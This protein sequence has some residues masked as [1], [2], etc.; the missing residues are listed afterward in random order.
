[1]FLFTLF[2]F[3]FFFLGKDGTSI[4]IESIVMHTVCYWCPAPQEVVTQTPFRPSSVNMPSLLPLSSFGMWLF[5]FATQALIC[6]TVSERE[7][8]SSVSE[9]ENWQ[10]TS[11]LPVCLPV[12]Y[13]LLPPP[14]SVITSSTAHRPAIRWGR[15]PPAQ[16]HQPSSLWHFE[17]NP[18]RTRVP[19]QREALCTSEVPQANQPA[20]IKN[21]KFHLVSSEG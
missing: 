2:H 9:Q 21:A 19:G 17:K 12:L 10:A 15:G 4:T 20:R 6:C 13:S 8:L 14:P 5:C 1:M 18:S 16:C 11:C 7:F 3:K